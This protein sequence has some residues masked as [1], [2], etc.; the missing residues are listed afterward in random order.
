[1]NPSFPLNFEGFDPQFFVNDP[2]IFL[3]TFF[4]SY[5]GGYC[6]PLNR[7]LR[8]NPDFDLVKVI[9]FADKLKIECGP[10]DQLVC[11]W[12]ENFWEK[13]KMLITSIF[14]FSHVIFQRRSFTGS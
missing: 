14:S 9:A 11:D 4:N 2:Q 10:N 8:E 1:M 3:F 13:E 6:D 12:V 7:K 5:E